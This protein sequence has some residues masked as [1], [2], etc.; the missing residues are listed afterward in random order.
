MLAL[1]QA[2]IDH[3]WFPANGA[4]PTVP[5]LVFA[6]RLEIEKDLPTL[7]RAFARLRQGRGRDCRLL[8]IGDDHLRSAIESECA[9]LGLGDAVDLP[10]WV[11]NPYPLLRR[12]ALVVLSHPSG[13]PCPR[14]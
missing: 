10:G 12:A 8:I 13:T 1:A 11:S 7:L 14:C 4:T 3:P 6:G 2:P 9:T 5:V